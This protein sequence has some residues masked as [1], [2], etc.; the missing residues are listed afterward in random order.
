[1]GLLADKKENYFKYGELDLSDNE[2]ES[3]IERRNQARNIK[4]FTT[5]DNIRDE[6]LTKGIVLEDLNGKTIWKKN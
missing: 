1:M 5:A 6:L 4:D 2:I 3:L